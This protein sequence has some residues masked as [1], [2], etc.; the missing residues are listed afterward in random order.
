L[1]PALLDPARAPA[2]HAT[3][4]QWA[5]ASGVE[6]V[7]VAL[8]VG[9]QTWRSAARGDG[10]PGPDPDAPYRVMSV[11]KTVTAVLVLR[12]VE[13]GLIALDAPLPAIDGVI[14]AVPQGVTVRH[15]LTH[16]SGLPEYTEVPGYRGD[17]ALTPQEAVELAL[18]VP[19]VSAPGTTTRY[20]NTNYHLLG[21]LL[22]QIHGRQYAD[23]VAGLASTVGIP[24]MR[25]DAPDRSGWPAFASG[26]IVATVADLALWG[27]AL[28]APGRA[29][30]P[31][32]LA[33]MTTDAADG[34]PAAW[35]ICPCRGPT[36]ADRFA[37]LGHTTAA[38]GLF[39]FP[40]TGVVLVVRADPPTADPVGRGASLH[41]ALVTA[42]DAP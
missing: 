1:R 20:V 9:G 26:G 3:L 24:G 15:L 14:P 4:Q 10:T 29:L 37:A 25:V 39:R 6:S 28:F 41:R 42:L 40:G 35:G 33:L 36:G 11:T 19:L 5:T 18:R 16:R 21:L 38:G 13:A 23:L 2:L 8:R 31:E 27:E 17:L 32:S 7:S 30:T 12:A 22:Q 34:A